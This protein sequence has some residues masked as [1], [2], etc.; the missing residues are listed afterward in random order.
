MSDDQ[1]TRAVQYFSDEYLDYCR[2]L[3]PRQ[4][5]EFIDQFQRLHT[6]RAAYARERLDSNKAS[7]E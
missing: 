1:S 5:L 7:P 4:I 2:Q 6:A 3:T